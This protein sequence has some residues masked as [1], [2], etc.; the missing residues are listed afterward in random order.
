[1]LVKLAERPLV[2]KYGTWQ[3]ILYR[4][5]E[6]ELIALVMGEVGYTN[7]T[8][9]ILCR[10]HSPCLSAH[11]LN[12]VE[13]DCAEQMDEAQKW[14]WERGQ[15][16]II[17]LLNHEG[18]GNGHLALMKTA[19]LRKTKGITQ[20]QAYRQIGCPGDAR[21]FAPAAAVLKDLGVTS[22]VLHTNN[23]EKVSQL[24]D[25]GVIIAGIE[26]SRI[27]LTTNSDREQLLRIQAGTGALLPRL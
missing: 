25:A 7:H 15:C 24:K 13:C 20:T 18:R 3:E 14:I 4:E 22:V 19:V 21:Q 26:R 9:G 1:M 12:S 11:Y 23:P 2:T 10:V 6:Q 8:E 5:G 17:I 16:L 27:D